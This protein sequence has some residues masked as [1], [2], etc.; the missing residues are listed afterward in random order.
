M[1]YPCNANLVIAGALL[2]DIGKLEELEEQARAGYTPAGH[3]VGHIVLGMQY[4]QKQGEQISELDA[5]TLGDLLH[6][7]LA[8]HTK[9][10]GSPVNPATIEALIVHQ[11]DAAEAHLTSFLEHC[12]RSPGSNGW[13]AYSTTHGGQLRMP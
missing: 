11:A 7:I 5:M 12:R 2:N 1:L 6:I 13:T 8:H 3:M 4:V 9:E 10:F